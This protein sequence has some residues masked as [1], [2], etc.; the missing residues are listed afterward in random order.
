M[1]SDFERML[2]SMGGMMLEPDMS[3]LAPAL[4]LAAI[5]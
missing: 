1:L 2:T 3:S 5:V 4:L